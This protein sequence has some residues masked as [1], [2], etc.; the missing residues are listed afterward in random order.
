MISESISLHATGDSYAALKAL[1]YVGVILYDDGTNDKNLQSVKAAIE[2]ITEQETQV[3][4]WEPQAREAR[5]QALRDSGAAKVFL[6][7]LS[8]L[9]AYMQKVGYYML[10]NENWG[11]HDPSGGRQST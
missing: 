5:I 8:G 10:M 2:H 6:P 4:I 9:R 7:C 1:E 11:F 3:T